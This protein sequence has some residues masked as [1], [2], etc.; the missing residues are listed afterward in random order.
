MWSRGDLNGDGKVGA[1]DLAIFSAEW[2][3]TASWYNGGVVGQGFGGIPGA[4][5]GNDS[6]PIPEPSTLSLAGLAGLT[7]AMAASARRRNRSR[8]ILA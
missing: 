7:F 4:G 3:Q 6:Q 5:N 1:S 8:R 2:G